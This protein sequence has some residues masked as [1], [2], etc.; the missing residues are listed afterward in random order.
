VYMVP[1]CDIPA[2]IALHDT[3]G[4]TAKEALV[5]VLLARG[6]IVEP[7]RIRDVYCDYPHTTPIE[8]RSAIKRIRKKTKPILCIR[9]YYGMG[10]DMEPSSCIRVRNLVR[11]V[12]QA[13]KHQEVLHT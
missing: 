13:Y 8:A 11:G 5:V 4:L 2:V 3:F 10:Y 9:T 12:V 7:T 1:V 6:G